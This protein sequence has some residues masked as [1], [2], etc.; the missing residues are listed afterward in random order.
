MI[1]LVFAAAAGAL[2]LPAAGSTTPLS[3]RD[4]FRIGSAGTVFCSAQTLATD[5]ALVGMFDRGYSVVCRDAA[6]PVGRLYALR[7]SGD[8]TARLAG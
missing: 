8:P 7:Q 6:Q 4:S 3:V 1:K 2:L 5:P